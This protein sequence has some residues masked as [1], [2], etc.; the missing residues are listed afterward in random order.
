MLRPLSRLAALTLVLVLV[1]GHLAE[2]Q[3]WL[4]TPEA[5]MACCADE[6][7]CP[8]HNA[9]Q[10][11]S[12]SNHR[13]SQSDADRCCATSEHDDSIPASAKASVADGPALIPVSVAGVL[14]PAA[15]R[16]DNPIEQVSAPPTSRS[17]HVVLSV[18]LI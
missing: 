3:A 6:Q 12:G 9:S 16:L 2:C 17:R 14:A 18:F 5:R 13:I 11:S 1:G 8:M 4:A 7:Q 10:H 15:T